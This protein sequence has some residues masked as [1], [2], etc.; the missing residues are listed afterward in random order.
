VVTDIC[1]TVT[2]RFRTTENWERKGELLVEGF[3]IFNPKKVFR[4]CF[5]VLL[6]T[7]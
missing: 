6:D 1:G 4:D 2:L 3:S 7:L 5:S